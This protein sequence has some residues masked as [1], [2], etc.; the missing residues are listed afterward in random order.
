MKY[1][2]KYI[3]VNL[4]ES[5]IFELDRNSN[6]YEIY[7]LANVKYTIKIILFHKMIDKRHVSVLMNIFIK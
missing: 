6:I 2:H 4:K 7:D 1:T 5:E 3:K